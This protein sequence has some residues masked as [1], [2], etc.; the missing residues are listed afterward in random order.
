MI[1]AHEHRLLIEQ[2]ALGSIIEWIKAG[3]IDLALQVA[4]Q[5]RARMQATTDGAAES[6][7]AAA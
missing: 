5:S 1:S 2:I 6:K 7:R 3:R 4:E